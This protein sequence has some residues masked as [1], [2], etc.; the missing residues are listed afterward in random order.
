MKNKQ[1]LLIIGVIFLLFSSCKENNPENDKK[2]KIAISDIKKLGNFDKVE[3]L[4]M[5][6]P[7]N[8]SKGNNSGTIR[9]KLFDSRK[10]DMDKESIA[11]QSAKLISNTSKNTKRYGTIWVTVINTGKYK[12]LGNVD[13]ES[14]HFKS[15]ISKTKEERNF[16]F[17]TSD[18]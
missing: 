14:K 15:N 13:F 18:L 11:K 1:I 7:S 10:M 5:G 2:L 16:I 8:N 3:Y 9:I 12:S 6:N 4:F 17:K